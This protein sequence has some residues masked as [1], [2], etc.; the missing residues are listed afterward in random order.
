MTHVITSNPLDITSIKDYN[1]N[2]IFSHLMK[3]KMLP[4]ASGELGNLFKIYHQDGMDLSDYE[5]YLNEPNFTYEF[6]PTTTITTAL[7]SIVQDIASAECGARLVREQTGDPQEEIV[8]VVACGITWNKQVVRYMN[9]KLNQLM[10]ETSVMDLYQYMKIVRMDKL[11]NFVK[12]VLNSEFVYPDDPVAFS[13][14]LMKT[15]EGVNI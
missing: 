9:T 5:E 7:D 13:Y 4:L 1:D 11:T 3:K 15:L 12:T 8:V 10:M 2:F 14:A 6:I